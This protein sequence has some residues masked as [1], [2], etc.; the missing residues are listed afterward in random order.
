[1]LEDHVA[2]LLQLRVSQHDLILLG[3]GV[4]KLQEKYERVIAASLI[5]T[6]TCV[7]QVGFES[8]PAAGGLIGSEALRP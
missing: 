8:V 6:L 3:I 7:G 4:A 5:C 1:M 2:Q